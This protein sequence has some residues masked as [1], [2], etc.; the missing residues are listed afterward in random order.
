VATFERP[1]RNKRSARSLEKL[2]GQQWGWLSKFASTDAERAHLGWNPPKIAKDM[3]DALDWFYA[4]DRIAVTVGDPLASLATG[5]SEI[6]TAANGYKAI[7]A[8]GHETKAALK[9]LQTEIGR[10]KGLTYTTS[11][12]GLLNGEAV[13]VFVAR[14]EI[15]R[16]V[17][18]FEGSGIELHLRFAL[19]L[20]VAHG[21]TAVNVGFQCGDFLFPSELQVLKAQGTHAA[22]IAPTEFQAK[23]WITLPGGGKKT[24]RTD[25]YTKLWRNLFAEYSHL[26]FIVFYHPIKKE[27]KAPKPDFDDT[28][29]DAIMFAAD[30]R[31]YVA[32]ELNDPKGLYSLI[33]EHFKKIQC[34]DVLRCL[35]RGSDGG[36]VVDIA[37]S[38]SEAVGKEWS[39]LDSAYR[40]KLGGL[41]ADARKGTTIIPGSSLAVNAPSPIRLKLLV[42]PDETKPN[43]K[44][45]VEEK[46]LAKD[47]PP[48]TVPMGVGSKR[49]RARRQPRDPQGRFAAK[50]G[51]AR[52]AK[53]KGGGAGKP[54]PKPKA[55]VKGGRARPRNKR[56]QFEKKPAK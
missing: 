42:K 39:T 29:W 27:R 23:P 47:R 37:I 53:P 25:F 32:T 12:Q 13:D 35:Y 51:A 11:L 2:L 22:P 7:Y 19:G 8:L 21:V 45:D 17:K 40:Y 30:K 55:K 33:A 43:R 3:K 54:K 44:D 36:D 15:G 28:R 9:E 4:K 34:D 49:G 20:A 31:R 26:R 6:N 38:K 10:L 52:S 48:K 1:Q 50:V 41:V 16:Q 46:E 14:T 24:N 5:L 56:G 18:A